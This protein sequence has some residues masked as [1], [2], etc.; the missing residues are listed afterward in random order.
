M[1]AE[2]LVSV[3]AELIVV[4][5]NGMKIKHFLTSFS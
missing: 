3:S 5:S 2:N 4:K 1:K